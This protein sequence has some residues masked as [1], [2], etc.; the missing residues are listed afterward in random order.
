MKSR[1]IVTEGMSPYVSLSQRRRL[2]GARACARTPFSSS[3]RDTITRRGTYTSPSKLLWAPDQRDTPPPCD[4]RLG[5]TSSRWH[6]DATARDSVRRENESAPPAAAHSAAY[7]WQMARKFDVPVPAFFASAPPAPP[8]AASL[9][10]CVALSSARDSSRNRTTRTA[11]SAM[12]LSATLA[13]RPNAPPD[14]ARPTAMSSAR[15]VV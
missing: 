7:S 5:P 11:S 3:K 1:M 9:A 15:I 4:T 6:S 12:L 13:S 10:C 2:A 14:T 8:M